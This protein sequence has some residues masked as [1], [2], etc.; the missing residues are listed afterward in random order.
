MFFLFN[1]CHALPPLGI[2]TFDTNTITR[3][4]GLCPSVTNTHNYW[5]SQ[6][7]ATCTSAPFVFRSTKS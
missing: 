5:S 4:L 6:E 3:I 2:T 1:L 7:L